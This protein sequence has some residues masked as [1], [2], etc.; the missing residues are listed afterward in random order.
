MEARVQREIRSIEEK[1]CELEKYEE[2]A[3]G[4]TKE[5]NALVV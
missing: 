4:Y 5:L 2:W 3:I 1:K